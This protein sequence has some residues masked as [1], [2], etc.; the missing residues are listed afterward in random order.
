MDE[1]LKGQLL[2]D[3]M[4]MAIAQGNDEQAL[5]YYEEY[6]KIYEKI[7]GKNLQISFQELKKLRKQQTTEQENE[8]EL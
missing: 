2:I 4:A 5:Q 8:I 1:L 6:K 3:D 7:T